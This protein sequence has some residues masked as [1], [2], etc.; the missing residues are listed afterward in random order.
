MEPSHIPHGQGLAPR[1]RELSITAADGRM[2]RR[3]IRSRSTVTT[4]SNLSHRRT[5]DILA[6]I[7]RNLS[8]LATIEY[9]D[10]IQQSASVGCRLNVAPALYGTHTRFDLGFSAIRVGRL[11]R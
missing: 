11:E 2:S 9:F 4:H 5:A 3:G 6:R 1:N 8:I 10:D 7:A